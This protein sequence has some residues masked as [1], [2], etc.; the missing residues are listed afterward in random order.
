M[1]RQDKGD[2]NASE[3]NVPTDFKSALISRSNL[4]WKVPDLIW[5]SR[6]NGFIREAAFV[7]YV[8]LSG[9]KPGLVPTD[10]SHVAGQQRRRRGA[11]RDQKP[12]GETG[13]HHETGVQPVGPADR[14]EGSGGSSRVVYGDAT[15]CLRF[16]CLLFV[17][18]DL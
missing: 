17:A 18:V 16:A 8:V 14:A 5:P 15:G 10:A 4:T 9:A 13:V 7:S 6:T 3:L 11:E 1:Q 2:L 12:A